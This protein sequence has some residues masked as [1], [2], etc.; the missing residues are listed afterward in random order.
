VFTHAY[1]KYREAGHF[2][3]YKVVIDKLRTG[4]PRNRGSISDRSKKF[5]CSREYL[6]RMLGP[7]GLLSSWDRSSFPW[8]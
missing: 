4:R 8:E 5:F 7:L 3:L 6:D 1:T 2:T